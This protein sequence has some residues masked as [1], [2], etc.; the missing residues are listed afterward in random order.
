MEKITKDTTISEVLMKNPKAGEI[1]AAHGFHCV[2]CP[3]SQMETLEIGAKAHG[4]KVEDLI[5]ELNK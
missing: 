3:M 4:V 1:L 5:K 2:G